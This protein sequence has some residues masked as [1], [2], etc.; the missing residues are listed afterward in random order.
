MRLDRWLYAAP[1]RLR[2]LFKRQQVERELAEEFQYHIERKTEEYI[3]AGMPPAAGRIAGRLWGIDRAAAFGDYGAGDRR[4]ALWGS[5]DRSGCV[6]CSA[7]GSRGC[8]TVGQLY[9]RTQSRKGGSN[10]RLAAGVK[11]ILEVL[12]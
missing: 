8:C 1:L 6:L 12:V 5:T 9:S 10:I 4:S 3:A 2:S 7:R 11:F